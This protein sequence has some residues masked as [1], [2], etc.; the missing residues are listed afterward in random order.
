MYFFPA[1]NLHKTCMDLNNTEI[2]LNHSLSPASVWAPSWTQ[3]SVLYAVAAF[4]ELSNSS[5]VGL[6]M[7]HGTVCSG[8]CSF[9]ASKLD[10]VPFSF[11]DALLSVLFFLLNNRSSPALLWGKTKTSPA[12]FGKCSNRLAV[13]PGMTSWAIC[14][15]KTFT[16]YWKSTSPSSSLSI[17]LASFSTSSRKHS[18]GSVW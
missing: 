8:Y 9:M 12:T 5:F 13:V 4:L 15:H 16:L 1:Y 11:I 6:H 2:N 10:S 14:H 7:W 17:T 3:C 18:S